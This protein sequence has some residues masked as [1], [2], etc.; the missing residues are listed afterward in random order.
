MLA[1]ENLFDHPVNIVYE[2]P[3]QKFHR[4]NP[5][6]YRVL[7]DVALAMRRGGKTHS[8]LKRIY[9]DIRDNG[10]QANGKPFKLDNNFTSHYSR[11]L[12][13]QEKELEG[14]F[15]TRS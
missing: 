10:I 1:Q 14:F 4:E 12:M 13:Q 6:V 3:F 5:H 11:L 15:E 9:E 7:R 8:S 2:T